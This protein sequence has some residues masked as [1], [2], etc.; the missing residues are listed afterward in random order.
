M[1]LTTQTTRHLQALLSM[2]TTAARYNKVQTHAAVGRGC[3]KYT[4]LI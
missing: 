1:R 2:P 4:K 3:F